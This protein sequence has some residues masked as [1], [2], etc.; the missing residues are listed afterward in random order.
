MKREKNFYYFL[1]MIIYII[2]FV[3][4]FIVATRTV[5]I[6]NLTPTASFLIYPMTYFL[7]IL[8]CER[9]GKRETKMLF[10]YSVFALIIMV[11]L[12]T[13]TSMLPALAN[14]GLYP[15]FNLDYRIVFSS[16][17]AFYVSQYLNLEIY[18]FISGFRGFRFLIASVIAA[19]IDGLL[20]VNLAYLGSIPFK[21]VIQ[22][23]TSQY[24]VNVFMVIIYTILFTYIIDSVVAKK[25]K[26]LSEEIEEEIKKQ[27]NLK[28][29][30]PK[31]TKVIKKDNETKKPKTTKKT[32]SKKETKYEVIQ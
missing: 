8:F 13:I 28:A 1:I 31:K 16:I 22:R 25:N 30:E 20:F 21:L 14:D 23:F 2:C 11:L 7:A 18:H 19:T 29:S 5:Q 10:N 24:V 27:E 17:T 6:G 4:S 3:T 9:Y 26:E 12:I 32:V 15:I